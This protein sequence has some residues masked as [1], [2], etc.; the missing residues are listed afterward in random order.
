MEF[1][2]RLGKILFKSMAVHALNSRRPGGYG[3]IMIMNRK[4]LFGKRN[5]MAEFGRWMEQ[6]GSFRHRRRAAARN[7]GRWI[8]LA[9]FALAGAL[10]V[11]IYRRKRKQVAERYTM[12]EPQGAWNGEQIPTGESIPA[13]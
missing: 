1:A 2:R 9:L 13:R 10:A 5:G 12:G 4:T 11:A 7:P 6:A 8:S 3:M